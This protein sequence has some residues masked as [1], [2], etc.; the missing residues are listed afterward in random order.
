[1]THFGFCGVTND[2]EGKTNVTWTTVSLCGAEPAMPGPLP[3]LLVSL[4]FLSRFNCKRR[5]VALI[6]NLSTEKTRNGFER[7][8]STDKKLHQE[9]SYNGKGRLQILS[10]N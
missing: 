10:D 3:F 2:R 1:M 5:K 7:R 9:I 8:M 6:E 4:H